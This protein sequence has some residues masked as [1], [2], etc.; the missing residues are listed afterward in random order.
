MNP[1]CVP[2]DDTNAFIVAIVVETPPTVLMSGRVAVAPVPMI[3][4]SV[5]TGLGPGLPGVPGIPCTPGMPCGPAG[6]GAPGVPL[7][8]GA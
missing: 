3:G 7:L 2:I 8:V 6:P 4:P 5:I 1:I